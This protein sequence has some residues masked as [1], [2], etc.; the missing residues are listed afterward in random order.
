[1]GLAVSSVRGRGRGK[2]EEGTC[3]RCTTPSSRARTRR[4][5]SA[6]ALK[7]SSADSTTGRVVTSADAQRSGS[8]RAQVA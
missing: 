7:A 6:C 3:E 1:V 4:R 5:R 2:Q 8:R